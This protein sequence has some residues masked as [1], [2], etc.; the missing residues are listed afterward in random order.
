MEIGFQEHICYIS[1][2]LR[3]LWKSLS[4]FWDWI[5]VSF[6]YEMWLTT[7]TWGSA[8]KVGC[9]IT[10]EGGVRVLNS[11]DVVALQL[12]CGAALPVLSLLKGEFWYVKTWAVCLYIWMCKWFILTGSFFGSV[13]GNSPS[14]TCRSCSVSP[15]SN[16]EFSNKNK[17]TNYNKK[18]LEWSCSF[19]NKS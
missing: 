6:W 5:F 11:Q 13:P 17:Q 3:Y 1:S 19:A 10:G 4:A 7:R 16:Q 15:W 2:Q 18:N 14:H 12:H 8:H 9:G